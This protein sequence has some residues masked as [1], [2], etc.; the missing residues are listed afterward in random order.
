MTT[1]TSQPCGC[2]DTPVLGKKRPR[3]CEHGN[4]FQS[5]KARTSRRAPMKRGRGLS[6]SPAQQRKVRDLPCIHCH[7]DRHEGAEIQAA[8]VYPRRF[9]TCDCAEGVVPLCSQAHAQY[10]GN[11]LDL[12]PLLLTNG[13]RA[14]FVHAMVEH[15]ASPLHVIEVVTGVVWKPVSELQAGVAA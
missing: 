3:T 6:A 8:H 1:W 11:R 4:V 15:E 9:A 10:D 2:T 5:E 14:E 7:R 13:Y 12:L